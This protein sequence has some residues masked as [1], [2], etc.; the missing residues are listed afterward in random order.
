M[1]QHKLY[2]DIA[3]IVTGAMLVSLGTVFLGKAT[4]L[5]GGSVGIG[6]LL[7]VATGISFGAAFFVINLPFFVL[8]YIRMG[9]Q[10]TLRTAL[11][12]GLVPVLNWAGSSFIQLNAINPVY[13]AVMGGLLAGIGL[14]VLFR[15]RTGLGGTNI[16]AL[17]LYERFGWPTGR[18]QLIIDLMILGASFFVLSPENIALSV[19]GAVIVSAVLMINHRA[20]RYVGVS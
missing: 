12:V 5:S 11:A 14:L 15:H 19:L 3:A 4:L 2:E 16:L 1:N 9:R 8:A 13:A 6:L 10:F 18:V 20:D 17:F 7:Q